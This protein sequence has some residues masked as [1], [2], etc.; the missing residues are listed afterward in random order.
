MTQPQTESEA[1]PTNWFREA[2]D[3]AKARNAL[4]PHWAK[5]VI[6]GGILAELADRERPAP[7]TTPI[8]HEGRPSSPASSEGGA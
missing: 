3:R 4:V 6:T 8:E 5:P 2:Y 7:P 1:R